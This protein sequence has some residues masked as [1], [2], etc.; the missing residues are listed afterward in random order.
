MLYV[1]IKT[2]SRRNN[3]LSEPT[4][5]WWS[6]TEGN[7]KVFVV[8]MMEE[9]NAS[10]EDPNSTCIK[11]NCIFFL[12]MPNRLQKDRREKYQCTRTQHSEMRP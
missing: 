7:G 4:S 1:R 5:E 11:M 2:N 6:L 10:R 12:K 8:I 9:A 3:Y